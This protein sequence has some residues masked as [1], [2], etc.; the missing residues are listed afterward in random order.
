MTMQLESA[1]PRRFGIDATRVVSGLYIGSRPPKGDRVARAGFAVL[2]LCAEELQPSSAEF[3][4]LECLVHAGIDDGR[5]SSSELESAAWAARGV[6]QAVRDGQRC[7]VTCAMGLN[8]SG[9]VTAL[10]LRELAGCSGRKARELVQRV[11]R[12]SLVNEHF[13]DFLDR[14]P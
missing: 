4:R 14:L 8:R 2:V 1:T 6:A 7:L 13:A 9:L 5:P 3:P 10:A 11:R 12:G